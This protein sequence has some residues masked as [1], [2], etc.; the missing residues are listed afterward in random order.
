MSLDTH[1]ILIPINERPHSEHAF[2]WA[3]HMAKDAKAELF[4]IHVIEIPLS[5]PLEAEF[6]DDIEQAEKLLNRYEQ[7]ARHEHRPKLTARSVRAR[8]AGAAVAKEAEI[9]QVDLVIVGIPFSRNLGQ[10]HLGTTG[11]YIFQHTSCEVLLW[12][13]PMPPNIWLEN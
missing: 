4:A 2:R 7:I 10:Y 1:R 13:E 3:C 12:R 5:M 9:E 6:T 11:S 8:Q